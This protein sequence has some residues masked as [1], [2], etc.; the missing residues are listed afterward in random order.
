MEKLNY[1]RASQLT[2]LLR[3][4]TTAERKDYFDGKIHVSKFHNSLRGQKQ[5]QNKEFETRIVTK[6]LISHAFSGENPSIRSLISSLAAL[7]SAVNPFA[8]LTV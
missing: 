7:S 8:S 5:L 6:L 3:N 4:E 1:P 2:E